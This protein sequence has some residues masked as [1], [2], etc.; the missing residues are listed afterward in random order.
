[1]K[2][3]RRLLFET[4]EWRL[5]RAGELS[6]FLE[7]QGQQ[8]GGSIE[9]RLSVDSD[10]SFDI[11]VRNDSRRSYDSAE[12]QLEFGDGLP[13]NATPRMVQFIPRDN[14]Q[15]TFPMGA[16]RFLAHPDQ[17]YV[18]ATIPA[19]NSLAIFNT[20]TLRMEANFFVGSRPL[21]L[22][23]SNDGNSLYIANS[24]SNYISVVDWKARR[25]SNR[26]L[27]SQVPYD[28]EVGK[29]GRLFVLAN[30]SLT[31]ID[32]QSGREVGPRFPVHVY[33]GELAI[34]RDQNRLYYGD[35]GLSPASLYQFDI[36][37]NAPQLLWESDHGVTSGDNGQAV[38]ISSDGAF[39]SYAAGYGQLGYRIAKYNTTNMAIEGTFDTGPYPHEIAFSPDG[40]SAFAMHTYEEIDV[41]DTATF[42]PKRSIATNFEMTFDG[43]E[44]IV[45]ASGQNIFATNGKEIAVFSTS[46]EIRFV[47][48]GDS[49]KNGKM[50]PGEAWLFSATRKAMPARQ[51]IRAI[52]SA[53]TKDGPGITADSTGVYFGIA[54]P[55]FI[56]GFGGFEETNPVILSG[57]PI[58]YT[59]SVA[60]TTSV[61]FGNVSITTNNGTPND[62]SDDSVGRLISG[63][64]DRNGL[65]NPGETW[66]LAA[67]GVAQRG[68]IKLVSSL[69][70]DL[71]DRIGT[72]LPG[73]IPARQS[74]DFAYFGATPEIEIAVVADG[75]DVSATDILFAES[76]RE[77][78]TKVFAANTGNVALSNVRIDDSSRTDDRWTFE[79][80]LGPVRQRDGVLKAYNIGDVDQDDQLDVGETWQ[81]LDQSNINPGNHLHTTTVSSTYE[82]FGVQK[83]SALSWGYRGVV[84]STIV[85]E[86]IQGTWVRS[87]AQ[88]PASISDQRF[89]YRDGAIYLK[90]DM[91]LSHGRDAIQVQV[92][93]ADQSQLFMSIY[94][95]RNDSPWHN[96]A[97]SSDV[98]QDAFVTP[99]DVL[100][101]INE[102]N[103]G[104]SRR[105]GIRQATAST[106][107]DVDA[108]GALSPLDALWVINE[109]NR[110]GLGSG[111]GEGES[112]VRPD[113]WLDEDVTDPARRKNRFSV[114]NRID[115]SR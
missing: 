53:Q 38:A 16:L 25:I 29:D 59:F 30:Q 93:F 114:Q 33:S 100:L 39:V 28:V 2:R 77:I 92:T 17:P 111:A 103:A 109:I 79:Q 107:L 24:T 14:R 68:N 66:V 102:L 94:V 76:G 82:R 62:L 20:N 51:T 58:P 19:S 52:G 112:P 56:A 74:I 71:V 7:V 95:Q 99:L 73:Q 72:K 22:A 108:D 75:I 34:S 104:G 106:L 47:N 101:L 31:Q 44:L 91:S 21:G 18:F 57:T 1:M 32:P 36:T 26:I 55:R 9:P 69:T 3:G 13:A 89:L 37:T 6:V 42:L 84:G 63:D 83:Q 115:A 4:L 70:A 45:D 88:T 35:Y 41:F 50:D 60:N 96:R 90:D 8:L 86:N 54:A 110:R 67:T 43:L 61:Y 105:L 97:I 78:V 12:V 11:S 64:H 27:I 46:Q 49:N 113:F 80:V 10:L 65:L 87:L 98:D 23:L 81:W 5:P 40:M 15:A 48:I 85:P